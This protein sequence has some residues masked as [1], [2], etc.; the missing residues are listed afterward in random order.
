MDGKKTFV[1][2]TFMIKHPRVLRFFLSS[3][4]VGLLVFLSWD[5]LS[6][7]LWYL[8]YDQING[9]PSARDGSALISLV[10]VSDKPTASLGF[11]SEAL[12]TLQVVDEFA[13]SVVVLQGP[14]PSALLSNT[15]GDTSEGATE[16]NIERE[17]GSIKG[18]IRTLFDAIRL[19]SIR[20][21]DA[22]RYVDSLIALVDESRKRLASPRNTERDGD[23]NRLV[24]FSLGLGN[25][26]VPEDTL[27]LN[28]IPPGTGALFRGYSRSDRP[29]S[30]KI[31]GIQ[32]FKTE[33]GTLVP[34]VALGALEYFL[35]VNGITLLH[36]TLS[37]GNRSLPLDFENALLVPPRRFRAIPQT[38]LSDY[39][40]E[41][42]GLYHLLKTM[43]KNGYFASLDPSLYP[44]NL[45]DYG[46][47]LQASLEKGET[48]DGEPWRE[49]RR[50]YVRSL[51]TL[52][53]GN[54]Q[55]DILSGLD[56]VGSEGGGT[57]GNQKRL[58]DL[59]SAVRKDFD[60]FLQRYRAFMDRRKILEEGLSGTFCV[61]GGDTEATALLAQAVLTGQTYRSI[62]PAG[63][64][65]IA[66]AWTILV[67]A[68][69][70]WFGPLLSLVV[71]LAA[72]ALGGS[73]G[74]LIFVTTGLWL[75][76]ALL[77]AA[78]AATAGVSA[79]GGALA[80]YLNTRPPG[81]R[82]PIPVLPLALVAVR[83]PLPLYPGAE[84][85][86]DKSGSLDT[87]AEELRRFRYN[88]ARKIREWGGSVLDT[89]GTV[90]F[91]AFGLPFGKPRRSTK[92]PLELACAFALAYS[93]EAGQSYSF[94]LDYGSCACFGG[95]GWG[96]SAFGPPVVR[97][98][99]LS[100][101]APRYG[102]AI[103]LPRTCTDQLPG[104]VE[105]KLLG[106][107]EDKQGGPGIPFVE[108]IDWK[109]D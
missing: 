9:R 89:D 65:F 73:V 99:I 67:A 52:A 79:L 23:F 12:Q 35:K 81:E 84:N 41:D 86:S 63:L 93:A 101:L 82:R 96:L 57:Q 22:D 3:L 19:G 108:L 68:L 75:A 70:P 100:G 50:Q 95:G 42:K 98:R 26:F 61:I 29:A 66:G 30:G 48:R 58:G 5:S 72:A 106:T 21:Q 24:Q 90:V 13:P 56:A 39:A 69:L 4:V 17:F 37:V 97:S 59:K 7:S 92:G 44:S 87:E 105:K 6:P 91:A 53:Q 8:G 77:S 14:F 32:P 55:E 11:F 51:R 45:Y 64:L 36:R 28:P 83:L 85:R 80:R 38:L 76:P 62:D 10:N 34:H 16:Q 49:A 1:Y 46:L 25:V 20:P 27:N 31:R 40:T 54:V 18:N 102:A 103:L 109:V 71:G 43:E 47:T 107:L 78:A 88:T 94:G 15:A 74:A 33:N 104:M 2:G 60:E